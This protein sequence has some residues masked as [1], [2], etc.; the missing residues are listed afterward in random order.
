MSVEML[1]GKPRRKQLSDQ[2]DRFDGIID[3]LAGGLPEAVAAATRDGAKEAI[4]DVLRELFADPTV[5]A[6]LRGTGA[7][8]TPPAEPKP[9]AWARL[10]ADVRAAATRVTTVAKKV[11]KRVREISKPA[12]D[13][14]AGRVRRVRATVVTARHLFELGWRVKRAV[15]VGLAVGVLVLLACQFS[16]TAASLLAGIGAGVTAAVV[17]VGVWCRRA[18]RTAVGTAG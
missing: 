16:H 9:S 12:A 6:L 15:A 5:R 17:H 14:I 7:A 3:A 13:A 2:L 18:V 8:P 4:A 10:K 1:N 11:A